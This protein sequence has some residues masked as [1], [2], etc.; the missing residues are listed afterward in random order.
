[1]T[2]DANTSRHGL[3]AAATLSHKP[4]NQDACAVAFNAD[5][6]LAGVVI[7]DGLGSHYG[8]DVAARVV[9]RSI[10]EDL[11][12]LPAGGSLD[13]RRLFAG[14][15]ARLQ[16]EVDDRLE[17]LPADLVWSTAF[18][19]TAICAVETDDELIVAYTGNG[20]VFHIRGNFNTFP[21]SQLLPWTAVNYLNPHSVPRDGKNVMYK[22]VSPRSRAEEISPSIIRISKDDDTFGDI[23]LCCSD[24]IYSYDQTSIGRDRE[25]NLW[26]SGGASIARFYAALAAQFEDEPS[27]GTL[28]TALTTYLK[29]LDTA[30][31]VD[32]DCTVGVLVT[33]KALAFQSQLREKRRESALA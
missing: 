10:A 26:I 4:V 8:A 15:H 30:G 7:A 13:P 31:L 12:S 29:E 16:R 11:E 6:P 9:V 19:T 2:M 20:G 17:L 5:V 24:G 23:I 1:M 21:A 22:I 25:Q 18:G 3:A 27:D 32:D 14:A 33:R 28:E